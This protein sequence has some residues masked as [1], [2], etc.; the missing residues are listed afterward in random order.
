MLEADPTG[1]NADQPAAIFVHLERVEAAQVGGY[2][3]RR[4]H[5]EGARRRQDKCVDE[6]MLERHALLIG[7]GALQAQAAVGFH[8]DEA[9]TADVH[10]GVPAGAGFERLADGKAA[11]SASRARH[12]PALGCA[13]PV[14]NGEPRSSGHQS[15]GCGDSAPTR[16]RP[17]QQF[18]RSMIGAKPAQKALEPLDLGVR[19]TRA[20]PKVIVSHARSSQ[21]SFCRSCFIPRC[22]FTRTEA[23]VMPVRAAISSPVMP[24]TSRSMSVSR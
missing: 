3:R 16:T 9:D 5:Y 22:R 2:G 11:R 6:A 4:V 19:L 14:A 1:L 24:S 15:G 10:G 8:F 23:A 18:R 13:A 21:S 12:L 7:A 20:I 17:Q